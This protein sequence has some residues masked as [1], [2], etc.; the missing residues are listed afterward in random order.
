MHPI[1]RAATGVLLD[2]AAKAE[3]RTAGLDF[4]QALMGGLAKLRAIVGEEGGYGAQKSFDDFLGSCLIGRGLELRRSQGEAPHP[5]GL[6]APRM[7][8]DDYEIIAHAVITCVEL[9]GLGPGNACIEMAA[10]G[11]LDRLLSRLDGLPSV[12]DLL[13]K[14]TLEEDTEAGQDDQ[15]PSRWLQ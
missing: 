4:T 2:A 14:L 11:L 6:P 5:A 1:L 8:G 3:R 9:N 15:M 13:S 12:T 10:A 7:M